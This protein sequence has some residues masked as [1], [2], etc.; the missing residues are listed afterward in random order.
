MVTV[1]AT[2]VCADDKAKPGDLVVDGEPFTVRQITDANQNG[3]IACR[4]SAPKTWHDTSHVYWNLRHIARPATMSMTVENPTNAE[5]CFVY[6]PLICG[7]IPGP[8]AASAEGKDSADGLVL[9]PMQPVPALAWFIQKNRSQYSDLKF[10]GSRDLPDLPKAFHVNMAN[11][12][13]GVGEKVTYTLNGKPVEEEFYAVHYYNVVQGEALWGMVCLHSFRAPAGTLDRRRNVF[14]AIPKSFKITPEFAQKTAS[15]HQQLSA[16][17][18]ANLKAG[19]AQI[20]AA[21]QRSKQLTESDNQFLANVDRSLVAG[22]SP[23]GGS[24][25]DAG[26]EPARTG[27]DLQDDYI[28]G[29][30]TVNDPVTGTSQHSLLEQYHWTDGYGN[31]RNSNDANYDPNKNENGDW[32]LMTPAR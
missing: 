31:Y 29:V 7:Y 19:Y 5:A 8:R 4:F 28:R 1:V 20:N 22:R 6:Q 18:Q 27:N 25:A 16:R 17:Y 2:K 3:M 12:Q 32:Q 23:A 26:G 11:N 9:H 10:I 15:V 24:T 14:A 30:D 21:A 13:H